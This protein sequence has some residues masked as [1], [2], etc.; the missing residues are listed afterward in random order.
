MM[1]FDGAVFLERKK[2][3]AFEK[4]E[5]LKLMRNQMKASQNA[6]YDITCSGGP[7]TYSLRT[8]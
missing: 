4:T 5:R 1:S 6:K 3:V 2:S 7:N 8:K